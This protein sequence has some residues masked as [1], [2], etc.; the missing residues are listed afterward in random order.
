MPKIMLFKKK[1]NPAKKKAGP[2]QTHIMK[3]HQK[4]LRFKIV[5]ETQEVRRYLVTSYDCPL[6]HCLNFFEIEGKTEDL[7]RSR[8]REKKPRI[9]FALYTFQGFH[10]QV[11][12][13]GLTG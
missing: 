12:A 4:N 8:K 3:N 2:N 13:R 6:H 11:S 9:I 5:P 10:A 7:Y 1:M